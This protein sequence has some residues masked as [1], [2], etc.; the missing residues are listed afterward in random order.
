[1]KISDTTGRSMLVDLVYRHP[2]MGWLQAPT[3]TLKGRGTTHVRLPHGQYALRVCSLIG[4]DV[5]LFENGQKLV[6]NSLA[7]RTQFVEFDGD[8]NALEFRPA[9]S[10]RTAAAATDVV[11]AESVP[12]TELI[13]TTPTQ[14]P[15]DDVIFQGPQAPTGHGLVYAVVRFAKQND[16]YGEPPQEEFEVAFQLHENSDYDNFFAENM[17]LVQQ[18]PALPNA[19]DP[20]S[21][22]PAT[23]EQLAGRPHVHCTFGCGCKH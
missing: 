18:A 21:R 10:P 1:M 2:Q 19:L 16:P 4:A 9:G 14:A 6:Q 8:R 12:A 17:H 23:A 7:P 5:I 11:V 13:V 15:G 22:Q 20:L 3:M